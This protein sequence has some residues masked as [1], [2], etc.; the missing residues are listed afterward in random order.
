MI[1]FYLLFFA[2]IGIPI[3]LFGFLLYFILKKLGKPKLGKYLTSAFG[4]LILGLSIYIIFEDHFFFKSDA[5]KFLSEQ[6][7]ELKDD[8]KIIKN[9]SFSA[10]GDYYHTFTLSISEKDRKQI[11][12]EIRNSENFKKENDTTIQHFLW[13]ETKN[14]YIGPKI[15]Q[16]YE[17]NSSLVREFFEPSGKQGYAPTFRQI[18][19]SKTENELIFKD[20]DE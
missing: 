17:T 19:I 1:E 18:S 8:F 16:N 15:I 11:I 14:R 13:L 12:Q 9:E 5:K 6:N 7:I 3:L 10:I 4:F 2:I 20:I